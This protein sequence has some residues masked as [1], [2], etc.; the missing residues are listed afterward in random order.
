[1][2]HFLIT[3]LLVLTLFTH[4]YA[5][6]ILQPSGGRVNSLGRCSVASNDFWSLQNNPAG[7]SSYKDLSIGLSYENRFLLKELGYKNVGL[8]F[9]LNIG[10]I[11]ISASQFGYEHYNENIIGIALARNFGPHLNIGLKLDYLLMKFS[12][13]YDNFSKPT[14]ELGIQ[15]EIKENLSLGVYLF[16]PIHVKIRNTINSEVQEFWSSKIPIIMRLGFSYF[17]TNNFMI[18]SEIEENSEEDFSCRF[19]LEYE[20]YKDFFIRSGF[21]LKPEVFTFGIGYNYKF[22][23]IDIAGQMNQNLGT[24]LNCSIVFKLKDKSK[25][26]GVS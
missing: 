1:M 6:D 8:L 14:F 23:L 11:G 16:N 2:K 19:G 24:S 20:C 9:P 12:G 10:V 26:G 13:D 22:C 4:A 18:C 7:F 17:I 15:Y 5:W 3:G 25:K 21:Q